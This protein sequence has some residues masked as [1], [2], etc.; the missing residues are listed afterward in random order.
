MS[1]GIRVATIGAAATVLAAFIALFGVWY[2]NR[3]S[4][5]PQIDYA[6]EVFDSASKKGLADAEATITVGAL[7]LGDRTDSFGRHTFEL[8]GAMS[9]KVAKIQVSKQSYEP[10]RIEIVVPGG[11]DSKEIYL[12]RSSVVAAFTGTGISPTVQHGE[13]HPP[14][15][16]AS[17]FTPELVSQTG[18][19]E[20]ETITETYRSGPQPSGIG[21]A[22]SAPYTV[23]SPEVPAGSTIVNVSY[24]LEGDR[25]CGAWSECTLS[26]KTD[27]HAC[28][29]FRLQ[30]HNEVFPPRPFMSEG[31]L[32]VT[33]V[34]LKHK[35]N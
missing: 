3:V 12:Y 28:F 5:T 24:R 29:Q 10:A 25:S 32:T 20:I 18:S 13:V 14:V 9:G 22:F 27:R 4:K 2:S 8:P 15:L 17:V 33:F 16:V 1:A 30:G 34:R 31:F 19:A 6:V 21:S 23:C 35:V 11:S 7:S 26:E